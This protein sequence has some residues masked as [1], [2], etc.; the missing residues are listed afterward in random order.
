MNNRRSVLR[1]GT[2][3]SAPKRWLAKPLNGRI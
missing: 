2:V 3:R 1:K